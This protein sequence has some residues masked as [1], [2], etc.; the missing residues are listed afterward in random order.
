MERL[1]LNRKPSYV[2]QKRISRTTTPT[3]TITASGIKNV[4]M[5]YAPRDIS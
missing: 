2:V 4:S 5:A 1:F 3:I